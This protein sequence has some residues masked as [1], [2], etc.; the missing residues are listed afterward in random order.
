M[1]TYKLPEEHENIIELIPYFLTLALNTGISEIQ[2]YVHSR[3]GLFIPAHVDRSRNGI[4]SQLGFIP[5]GLKFDAL[6]ISRFSSVKDVR[7]HYVV[8]K[9]ITLI[10]N[11]D[12]HTLSPIGEIYSIFNMNEISFCEIKSALNQRD[13]HFVEII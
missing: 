13:S 8:Q 9:E 5:P 3:N 1:I 11:S 7:K 2:N 6:G 10:R 12:A 4:F